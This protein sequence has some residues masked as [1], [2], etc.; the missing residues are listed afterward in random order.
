MSGLS[1]TLVL[2][3]GP[4]SGRSF[5]LGSARAVIGR[6]KGEILI[7]DAEISGSHAEINVSGDKVAIKDLGS[8]NGTFVNGKKLPSAELKDGDR[9]TIGQSKILVKI[10]GGMAAQA[11][12]KST[13][14]QEPIQ[15]SR[16]DARLGPR[17]DGRM[18][19]PGGNGNSNN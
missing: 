1:V 3:A 14:R 12:M 2:E 13:H 10:E 8:T 16:P 19:A 9:L 7:K 5:K 18:A 17:S 4:E 15:P 11:S 6:R